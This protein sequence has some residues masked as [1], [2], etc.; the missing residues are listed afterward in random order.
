MPFPATRLAL[1]HVGTAG[2]QGPHLAARADPKVRGLLRRRQ[3][4][5]RSVRTH[6]V[7]DL[8]RRN[9]PELS[10]AAAAPKDLRTTHD[11]RARQRPLP[12]RTTPGHVFAPPCSGP[13]A[14]VSAALQ[15]A[16]CPDRASLET[17][18][19]PGDAQ[20]LL[21][22]ASRSAESCHR[23]LRSLAPTEHSVASPMLHYLRRY[24]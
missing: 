19:A 3:F 1:S 2:N 16:T 4:G 14:A 20:S 15:P 21:R 22:N 7:R 12:S 10:E 24:V 17:G 13:A 18:T 8:Q 11:P 6:D 5:H 23:L 9:V